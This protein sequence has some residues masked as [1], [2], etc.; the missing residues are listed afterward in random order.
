MSPTEPSLTLVGDSA[1]ESSGHPSPAEAKIL[2]RDQLLARRAEARAA[3]RRVVHCHGCFDIVHPGHLRHLRHA[4]A[5]GDILLVSITGDSLINKGDGRP[6]IPQ[7]L[8]AENL[9]ALDCV[10]WV[11][12]EP[13]PTAVELLEDVRPDIYVKG[14]EYEFNND[15]RFRA[16]QEAVTR[17]GGRVVF[18]SGDVVFSSTAL[19]AALEHSADP[20]HAR[21]KA[22]LANTDLDGENLTRTISK[23]RGKRVLVIGET[24]ADT[25]VLCDRPDIA[26]ESPIMTLRP[27]E[28]RSYDGAAAIIARHLAAMGA[29]PTLVT[30]MPD[31]A[32]CAAI[33]GRLNAEGVSVRPVT[34]DTPLPEK[35][36]FLVGGQKVM[37]LDLVQPIELDSARQ[38]LLTGLAADAAAENGG[39]DAAIIADFGL[40]LL[41]QRVLGRVSGAVRAKTSV[42]T[43][44]VS[45]RRAQ[46][47]AMRDFDLLCPS[48]SEL[49]E[50]YHLHDQ[51]LPMVAWR[52]LSETRSKSAIVTMGAEGL[53]AFDRLPDRRDEG[54]WE[55]KLKAEHVPAMSLHAIDALGCGDALLSAATLGLA[56]GCE[57]LPSAFLGAIAAAVQV[58]RLGNTVVGATDL[59]HGVVRLHTS[60]LTYQSAEVIESR[61]RVRVKR[62]V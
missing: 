30:A 25:Y 31:T 11:Y 8:R 41:S 40:G 39:C 60:H 22:L 56:C 51:G 54:A 47:R 4:R 48:E 7:E 52:L 23:F 46:L 26:G 42:M 13:R 28:R 61:S 15:P 45:G 55:H 24:I 49:R 17:H 57:M 2:S 35:Q 38:D 62:A 59:R 20:Y 21:M 10:D 12:I 43:G 1:P 16:E 58:Q 34:I 3:G 50:A 6:L 27:V 36:R 5:Q 37:K 19:I 14:R 18:S 9:A 53:I 44:D 29:K 33:A 32:E